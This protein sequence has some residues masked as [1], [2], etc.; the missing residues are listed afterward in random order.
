MRLRNKTIMITGASSGIGAELA[1]IAANRGAH[2]I[3][4]ARNQERLKSIAEEINMTGGS[5]VHYRI[6]L[7]DSEAIVACARQIIA[8]HGSPDVLV[9]NA[10][11]GKWLSILETSPEQIKQIMAVPYFS[12]FNLTREFLP[13]M[14]AKKQ[15]HIV[16]VTSVASKL[17]WPGSA[18]YTSTRWAIHGFSEALRSEVRDHGINV[19][20]AMF[21]KIS[22]EYWDHNPG[23]EERLPEITRMVPTIT[24]GQAAE[25]II[26]GIERNKTFVLKPRI[27]RLVLWMNTMFPGNTAYIMRKTGWRQPSNIAITNR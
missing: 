7:A 26:K 14:I 23:S 5:A 17:I 13:G 2:V 19:T 27:L 12:S 4:L 16:N 21:G 22:S 3:M 6:D 1:K 11:A 24:S 25:A 18:A 8:S 15:G 10:G 20:L 9:N